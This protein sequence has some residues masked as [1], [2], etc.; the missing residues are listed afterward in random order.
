MEMVGR[1]KGCGV[2]GGGGI[3]S[4]GPNIVATVILT[5]VFARS[6]RSVVTSNTAHD[7]SPG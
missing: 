1:G 6:F 5:A 2:G 3:D 4:S 7:I